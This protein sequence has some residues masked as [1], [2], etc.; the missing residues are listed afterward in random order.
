MRSVTWNQFS[1]FADR[2]IAYLTCGEHLS[3]WGD[4]MHVQIT[5]Q[6][7][8]NIKNHAAKRN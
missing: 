2:F 8:N 5:V 4:P 6:Q 7:R 3:D 1:K